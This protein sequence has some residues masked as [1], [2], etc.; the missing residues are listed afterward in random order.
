MTPF[1]TVVHT[2]WAFFKNFNIK[3]ELFHSLRAH[4]ESFF[5]NFQKKK[6]RFSVRF[7]LIYTEWPP[8]FGKFTPK[9]PN[10]FGSHTQWSPFVYKI[11]TKCPLFS[12]SGKHIPVTFIF[13]C[14]RI[15]WQVLMSERG[16]LLSHLAHMLF[17][18]KLYMNLT[19]LHLNSNCWN[20]RNTN[21]NLIGKQCLLFYYT[22]SFYSEDTPRKYPTILNG[23]Q[24]AKME[25]YIPNTP[26]P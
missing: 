25:K 26:L 7:D 6:C 9:K 5:V 8:I 15:P 20:E 3:F 19:V 10:I 22:H 4:F 23:S 2:Q 16:G 18:T 11:Y 12:F 14:P 1:F 24:L 13:E 21:K 17:Q